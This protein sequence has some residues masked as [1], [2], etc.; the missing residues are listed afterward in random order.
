MKKVEPVYPVAAKAAGAQGLV[1]VQVMTNQGGEVES[2]TALD[3]HA[4]LQPAAVE[5]VKQ[6]RF[7]PTE[8]SEGA[9]KMKSTIAFQF[10][11]PASADASAQVEGTY[12]GA[13]PHGESVNESLGKQTIEGVLA[14][15]TRTTFTIPENA[16]GNER[17]IKIVNE[18]WF[19]PDLQTVVMTKRSDPRFGKQS[20]V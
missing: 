6:W 17:P 14:E 20:T 5:A 15:G 19:S 4:L 7:K 12:I 1:R 16:I 2:A 11:L 18:R 10:V 9:A 3:G 8:S 13:A